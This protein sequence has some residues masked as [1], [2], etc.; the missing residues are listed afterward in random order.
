MYVVY[1]FIHLDVLPLTALAAGLRALR[2]VVIYAKSKNKKRIPFLQTKRAGF[3]R[4]AF[5]SDAFHLYEP[6]GAADR[7]MQDNP[8][9]VRKTFPEEFCGN[10][11]VGGVAQIYQ[12]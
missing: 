11:T 2:A 12:H 6:A 8:R 10:R 3:E 5:C 1:Y 7:R 4:L 9:L